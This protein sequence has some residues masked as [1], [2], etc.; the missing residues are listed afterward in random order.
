M[1]R[2]ISR[3]V[4]VG[5]SAGAL[6]LIGMQSLSGA[7][8]ASGS[9][10]RNISLTTPTYPATTLAYPSVA[11]MYSSGFEWDPVN[12]R[13]VVADTGNNLIEFYSPAGVRTGWFGSFG[14]GNGQLNSPR[15]VAIDG[16]GNIYVA[17]AGN[18]QF[19][20]SI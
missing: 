16:S 3:V 1:T 17:D 14:S 12:H 4:S 10:A 5:A 13:I 11:H 15:D 8:I 18:S 6:V 2:R 9:G 20:S 7:A 19:R